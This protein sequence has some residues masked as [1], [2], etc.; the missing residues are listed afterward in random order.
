VD[1]GES[2]GRGTQGSLGAPGFPLGSPWPSLGAPGLQKK[3]EKQ[4]FSPKSPWPSLGAPGLPGCLWL[5]PGSLWSSLGLPARS[6][7]FLVAW[8]AQ[9]LH[10]EL[11]PWDAPRK[12]PQQMT[13]LTSLAPPMLVA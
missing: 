9:M 13:A 5:S 4:C 1:L 11:W 12:L 10:G 2:Q 8:A 6:L 7:P 3:T